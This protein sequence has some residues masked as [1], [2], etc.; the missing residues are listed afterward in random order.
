MDTES[1]VMAARREA[2]WAL[3]EEVRGLRST[4]RWLRHSHGDVAHG[5]GHGAAEELTRMTHGHSGVGM[6]W[7]GG[8]WVEG[9]RGKNQDNCNRII[10]KIII[11]K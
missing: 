10:N 7:G 1:P 6:A 8:C 2:P 9:E 5:T 11:K 4:I 3:G